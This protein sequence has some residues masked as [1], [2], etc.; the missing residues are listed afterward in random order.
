MKLNTDSLRPT[1]TMKIK[2]I[3]AGPLD[4]LIYIVCTNAQALLIDPALDKAAID[5]FLFEN[6]L[7]LSAILLTHLHPDH[8]NLADCFA[9]KNEMPVFYHQSD[10]FMLDAPFKN[11][12]YV[13]DGENISFGNEKITVIHTPGHTPGSC[14]YLI[15]EN[16]FTG[17]TLFAGCC[18]RTDLPRSS[19][20]E[21]AESLARLSLL[22]PDTKVYPGHAYNKCKT[23]IGAEN[24]NNT[25]L[26]LAQKNKSALIKELS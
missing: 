20:I 23:T 21:M 13:T 26:K 16:L 12:K 1:K 10:E 19:P 2:Q 11:A 4:N 24:R 3:K 17:D 18:G 15:N 25:Y 8:I 5:D 14:C 7:S 6:S 9:K 22:N